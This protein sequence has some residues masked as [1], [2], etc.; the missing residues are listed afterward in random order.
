MIA[1]KDKAI[2]IINDIQLANSLGVLFSTKRNLFFYDSGT[3]K[4]AKEIK[5]HYPF[6]SHSSRRTLGSLKN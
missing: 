3:G 6:I 1:I 5:K 2:R 4:N